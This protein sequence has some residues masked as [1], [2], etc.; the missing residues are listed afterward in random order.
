MR[1]FVLIGLLLATQPSAAEVLRPVAA[2]EFVAEK[3]F[4]F[5]CFEGTRGSGRIYN[6]GSVA[7]AIQIR[8][9]GEPRQVTLPAGTLRLRGE[10][11]CASLAGVPFEPC[12]EVDRIGAREFRGSL[13]AVRWAFCEF[14]R[15][16]DQAS[17]AGYA[18][19]ARRRPNH[20]R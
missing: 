8:G 4:G 2:R 15:G 9:A 14:T 3:L 10:S 13:L 17:A 16:G 18:G 1:T 11:Y 20:S 5:R 19:E 7:G 12:F 6:D